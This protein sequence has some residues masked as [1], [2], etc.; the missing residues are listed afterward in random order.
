MKSSITNCL[1]FRYLRYMRFRKYLKKTRLTFYWHQRQKTFLTNI[2]TWMPFLQSLKI[3]P[4]CRK[5]NH[6][7]RNHKD[8]CQKW[9]DLSSKKD[10]SVELPLIYFPGSPKDV[11]LICNIHAT[12][13]LYIFFRASCWTHSL[14]ERSFVYSLWKVSNLLSSRPWKLTQQKSFYQTYQR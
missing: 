3:N 2:K 1:R 6:P 7:V 8:D 10:C 12:D 4:M 9:V 13:L 5:S 14:T 11:L